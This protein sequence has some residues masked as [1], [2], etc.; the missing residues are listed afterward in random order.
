MVILLYGL[1]D[2][3][4]QKNL[5]KTRDNY[6][7]KYGLVSADFFDLENE[8]GFSQFKN[9]FHQGNLFGMK[10]MGILKN[11][12]T[13]NKEEAEQ[14][15]TLLKEAVESEETTL[16]VSEADIAGNFQFIEEKAAKKFHYPEL[17]SGKME[18][19]IKKESEERK[20]NLTPETIRLM[21]KIFNKDTWSLITELEKMEF[22]ENKT[23][24]TPVILEQ[25]VSWF[26]EPEIFRFID[27]V[28][29]NHKANFKIPLLENIFLNKEE[30]A[31][32]F[33]IFASR[34]YLDFETIK[35]L[36]DY[37]VE[38]KSGKI[39]YETALLDLA[40]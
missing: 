40:L 29:K 34:Q 30:P 15:K 35:K 5:E 39:D 12:S 31:K 24:I 33:N 28:S 22:L 9:F 38:I 10:K 26:E 8:G 16:I 13:L 7:E 6:L 19:F 25:T 11:I 23:P 3:R 4:R 20:I 32:I 21:S 1:D 17:E 37:D 18:F 14:L 2:Y 36:A 27:S